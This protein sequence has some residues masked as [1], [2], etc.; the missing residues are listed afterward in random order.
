MAKPKYLTVSLKAKDIERIFAKI[1]IDPDDPLG[2]CWIW[3]GALNTH[4]YGEVWFNNRMEMS[5]RLIYAWL[6]QPIPRGLHPEVPCL[7]HIICDNPRCCNPNHL[8][9]VLPRENLART[10]SVSAVNRRKTHC[11]RGHPLPDKPNRSDGAG[12]MCLICRKET[13]AR[14]YRDI[15]RP[16]RMA[17]KPPKEPKL[18]LTDEER[19]QKSREYMR[20]YRNLNRD[21]F[22][23]YG[24]EYMRERRKQK[25]IA[26]S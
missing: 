13:G 26:I 5:H 23:K 1:S 16:K 21:K 20:D 4:G 6:V 24:R 22:R 10:N 25:R 17:M 18:Q 8:Q 9:L 14:Y 7:D 2:K 15:A 19:R 3:T 11:I 12:R